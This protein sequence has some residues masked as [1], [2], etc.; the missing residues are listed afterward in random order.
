MAQKP[1]AQLSLSSDESFDDTKTTPINSQRDVLQIQKDEKEMLAK[2]EKIENE[3][4]QSDEQIIELK[5]QIHNMTQQ[6][7][8]MR[9][10]VNKQLSH[11]EQKEPPSFASAP[12]STLVSRDT[13]VTPSENCHA[14]VSLDE[15][16]DNSMNQPG[17][18][19][20]AS[21][22]LFESGTSPSVEVL[23]Q[24]LLNQTTSQMNV[25]RS[26]AD[27]LQQ[28][29]RNEIRKA[30]PP[31]AK[32]SGDADQFV[33]FLE[34]VERLRKLGEYDDGMMKLFVLKSLDGLPKERIR[35]LVDTMTFE[36]VMELLTAEFGKPER[37][38]K[39]TMNNILKIKV[40][41]EMD[42]SDAMLILTQIKSFMQACH[43]AKVGLVNSNK[44]AEHIFDTLTKQHKEKYLS[45]LKKN[46]PD[47]PNKIM[48]LQSMYDFLN[49]LKD[50]LDDRDVANGT[51]DSDESS[52]SCDESESSE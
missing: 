26:Q 44:L 32:Y 41:K 8:E 21:A 43:F 24:I 25:E 35:T 46:F 15:N 48:D 14:N 11:G 52:S 7:N 28:H 51:S 9:S 10:M 49:R 22:H 20:S 29:N 45:Y 3:K 12:S 1:A 33:S 23:A 19:Y 36:A 38:I 5:R 4:R 13:I 30:L 42:F 39:K 18:S 47:E 16:R 6:F 50:R 17:S 27:L 37:V 34:D 2:L 40:K 31:I